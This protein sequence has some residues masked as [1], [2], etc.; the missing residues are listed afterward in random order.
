MRPDSGRRWGQTTLTI[1]PILS[2]LPVEYIAATE[3]EFS[4]AEEY[5]DQIK[6]TPAYYEVTSEDIAKEP[7]LK[8]ISSVNVELSDAIKIRQDRLVEHQE[9]VRLLAILNEKCGFKLFEG[10]F[11]CLGIK[12][13]T[14]LLYEVKTILESAPDQEK[15]TVK[16]VGQLKY[17]KFSIVQQQMNLS[18]IREVLVFSRKPDTGIIEFCTAENIVVIWRDGDSFQ[19]FNVLTG[20]DENFNP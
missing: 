9:I 8:V 12:G 19:I 14:A 18:N 5:D 16:G 1:S 2:A 6:E 11:D 20:G 13:D 3:D 15:Q 4:T 7:I 17:Y 10:K